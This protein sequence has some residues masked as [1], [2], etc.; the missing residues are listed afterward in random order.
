MTGA[1]GATGQRIE[2]NVPFEAA[3]KDFFFLIG[4]MGAGKTTLGREIA[5]RLSLPF[6]DLDEEIER[7]AGLSVME[8]FDRFGEPGFRR[9][10][11]ASLKS[12]IERRDRGV[13]ATGGGAFTQPENRELMERSGRTVWLNVSTDAILARGSSRTR[14]LW[15]SDEEARTLMALRLPEYRLAQLQLRLTDE[16]VEEGVDRLHRLLAPYCN[17]A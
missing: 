14:P 8:I 17:N 9:R 1:P 6:F 11:Q 5:R 2:A 3:K 13:I 4:F 7:E 10:E 12:L 15:R 16:T